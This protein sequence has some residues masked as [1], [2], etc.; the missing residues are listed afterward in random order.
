MSRTLP[1]L[2]TAMS[3]V[4]CLSRLLSAQ[5]PATVSLSASANPSIFGQPVTLSASVTPPQATGR[6]VFY[7]GSTVLGGANL[8]NGNASVTAFLP[9]AGSRSLTAQFTSSTGLSPATAV[10]LTQNVNPVPA[11]TLQTGSSYTTTGAFNQD[12]AVAD[13]NGD[14]HL[15]LVTSSLNILFGNGDG[16]FRPRCL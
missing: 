4:F 9:F 11:S 2:W 15:D 1:K 6:I 13:F 5:T 14:G 16:T 3:F 7:D 8:T 12:V 10:S